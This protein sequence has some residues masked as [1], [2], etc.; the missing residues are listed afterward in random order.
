METLA[1]QTIDRYQIQSLLGEGGMGAVYK[2]YD[3]RL[4]RAVAIKVM[5]PFYASRPEFQERF[6]QEGRT[7]AHLDHPGI[8]KVHDSGQAN[9]ILYIVM[10]FI[11][12]D[13]LRKMLNRMKAAGQEILVGEAAHL[14]RQVC[15][16]IDYAHRL[17]VLYR[18]IKPDNI[19]IKDEP[20]EGLPYKPV[21]TDLGLAKLLEGIPITRE[22]D[23][24]GTP[25]YM[26]PEQAQGQ[27]TDVRSDVYSLGILLYELA[28]GRLPFEIKTLAEAIRYHTKEPPPS[29]R[30]VRPELP[31]ALEGVILKALQKDPARRYQDARSMAGD[32]DE[33][34]PLKTP[35]GAAETAAGEGAVSLITQFQ[36]IPA[37]ALPAS[38]A[39]EFPSPPDNLAYD[40]IQILSTDKTIRTIL[41]KSNSLLVGRDADS[42]ILLDDMS[43]SRHHARIEFDGSQYRVID[44]KSTN[45]V[46]QE[47]AKLL[48]GIPEV[49][50]PG[51]T[52][53]IGDHWLRLERSSRPYQHELEEKGTPPGVSTQVETISG[54]KRMAVLLEEANLKVDPGIGVVTHVTLQNQGQAA[55]AFRVSVLG[56]PPAWLNLPVT[57]AHLNPGEQQRF[58]LMICPPRAP[59]SRVGNYPLTVRMTSRD[60]PGD[61]AE[62]H[63]TLHLN[64]FYQFQAGLEPPNASGKEQA[65]YQVKLCNSG[66]TQMSF[67]LKAA[68]VEAGCLFYFNPERVILPAGGEGFAELKVQAK[69]ALPAGSS[70]SYRFTVEVVPEEAPE[71]AR[72]IEGSFVHGVVAEPGRGISEATASAREAGVSTNRQEDG[73]LKPPLP[74]ISQ[75]KVHERQS[76][77]ISI[78]GFGKP[79]LIVG[80]FVMLGAWYLALT[81]VYRMFGG[82]IC[83]DC[84]IGWFFKFFSLPDR[85]VYAIPRAIFFLIFGFM[86]GLGSGI[87]LRIA[88]R[89]FSFGKILLVV[90]GWL[91]VMMIPILQFTLLPIYPWNN[92]YQTLIGLVQGAIIGLI[93]SLALR[94]TKTKLSA[95]QVLTISLAWA[96]SRGII[97]S[98]GAF[99]E[100][101]RRYP[102]TFIY[103]LPVIVGGSWTMIQ[104]YLSRKKAAQS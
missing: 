47:G 91:F 60:V 104:I 49:W 67:R 42:D 97:S 26:S 98:L 100:M 75:E 69:S 6:L 76:A 80:W 94:T 13:N 9:G 70:H 51:K 65:G 36:P 41:V 61:A 92:F 86:I 25:A 7:A 87:A 4:A 38:M 21:L 32:I 30:F 95:S 71:T 99:P 77:E 74:R 62:D 10:E 45:G 57:E 20:Y 85:F 29:P 18:D 19:M 52:L 72:Q 46:Y 84:I 2:A 44:L 82:L 53:Q 101:D 48:P 63:A 56:L 23:S 103:F 14:V 35:E 89:S 78:T 81:L 8:V 33:A 64:P 22:G 28:L 50:T 93:I 73:Q 11:P 34:V 66:N 31:P 17:G 102:N 16:A 83:V 90:F 24:L 37:E 12:G 54:S 39:K 68:D 96:V 5:H 3:P 59:E 58:D 40:R 88:E 55:E 43:V 79:G 15:L 1:G 27:T